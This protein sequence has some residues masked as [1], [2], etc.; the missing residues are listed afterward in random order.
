MDRN[1]LRLYNMAPTDGVA[2]ELA[3]HYDKNGD[4]TVMA[5]ID[6]V[7]RCWLNPG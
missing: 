3:Y 7:G 4:Y 6:W 5:S 2:I 1:V